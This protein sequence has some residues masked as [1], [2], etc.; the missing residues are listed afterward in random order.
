MDSTTTISVRAEAAGPVVQQVMLDN[1][2]LSTFYGTS[3]E[4]TIITNLLD[5]NA[6]K[7]A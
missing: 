3:N 6:L 4:A 5:D 7:T 1:I 2:N